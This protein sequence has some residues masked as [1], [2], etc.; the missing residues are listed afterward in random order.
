MNSQELAW[1]KKYSVKIIVIDNKGYG[2]IRQ[3]QRQFYKSKFYGSDFI[4]KQ[5]SLPNF[6]IE[7]ILLSFGIENRRIKSNIQK[8]DLN[9]L[10]VTNKSKAIILNVSYKD[11]VDY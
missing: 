2:I 9:W 4:N 10:S 6:S 3:T 11:Q 8:K 5:S 7:K 1:L